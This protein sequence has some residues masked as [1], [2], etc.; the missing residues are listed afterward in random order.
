MMAGRAAVLR[1]GGSV[2]VTLALLVAVTHVPAVRA[3]S[4]QEPGDVPTFAFVARADNPVDALAASSIAGQLGGVVV[5][6]GSESLGEDARAALVAFG[7]AVVVLAGGTTALSSQVEADA[8]ALLPQATVRRV[9]GATRTGTARELAALLAELGTGRPVLTDA[10][11]TGDAGVRGT[12][13]VERLAVGSSDLVRGLNAD[14]LDGLSAEAFR[15]VDEDVDAATLDGLSA[16]EFAPAPEAVV[17][18]ASCPGVGFLPSSSG[19]AYRSFQGVRQFT[20][21]GSGVFTCPIQL[22]HGARIQHVRVRVFDDIATGRI[23]S[24]GLWRHD[25]SGFGS[26]DGPVAV[27][28]GVTTDSSRSEEPIDVVIPASA[29]FAVVDGEHHSFYLSVQYSRD[30]AG[31]G[32][33]LWAATVEYILTQVPIPPPPPPSG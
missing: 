19:L 30:T 2:A 7:P 17:G 22:P 10:T 31:F 12:M 8:R 18:Y 1:V 20:A 21:A 13:S 4:G 23:S 33:D 14:L 26:E 9:A 27:R 24:A 6:T 5:L 3:Q 11:V 16:E 28:D 25:T 29:A 15:R 32:L